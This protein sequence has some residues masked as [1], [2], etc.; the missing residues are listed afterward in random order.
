MSNTTKLK[1]FDDIRIP[2]GFLDSINFDSEQQQYNYFYNHPS[3]IFST[4]NFSPIHEHSE[5]YLTGLRTTFEKANYMMYEFNNKWYYA[6][7]N[8]IVQSNYNS[9]TKEGTI[10]IE[11]EID[12]VQTHLMLIKAMT[13]LFTVRRHLPNQLDKISERIYDE[14]T[15]VYKQVNDII[16]YGQLV[17]NKT[18]VIKWIVFVT[19]RKDVTPMNNGE[20]NPFSMFVFPIRIGK[21]GVEP[22]I[23]PYNVNGVA[24]DSLAGVETT[25]QILTG[26]TTTGNTMTNNCVNL[27][28]IDDI[29]IKWN[30]QNDIIII[31]DTNADYVT[32]PVSCIKLLG[33][34]EGADEEVLPMID[35]KTKLWENLKAKSAT[36]YQLVN[37]TLCGA[38]IANSYG[39]MTLETKNLIPMKE[40]K[41]LKRSYVTEQGSQVTTLKGYCGNDQTA[42]QMGI[43]STG[44]AQTILS[45]STATYMQANKNAF[46]YKQQSLNVQ[47]EQLNASQALQTSNLN[48]NISFG[49][50]QFNINY[51]TIGNIQFAGHEAMGFFNTASNALTS[52][53]QGF[54]T[55]GVLGG[56]LN[57]GIGLA[58]TALKGVDIY[59][60]V[61]NRGLQEDRDSYS[62][63]YAQQSVNL[64]QQQAQQ[65]MDMARKAFASENADR[66]LQPLTINQ[67]G[68][69]SIAD[70][71]NDL[72]TDCLITW[73]SDD[74]SIKMANNE[75]RR[76]GSF[77]ADY[78]NMDEMLSCRKN[79]NRI[80]VTQRLIL[81]LNQ[82]QKEIIEGAFN[83][84]IRFWN[85][86]TWGSQEKFDEHFMY[87]Y[88]CDS[89]L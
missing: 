36:E 53:A 84:G 63:Q 74:Y 51:G 2:R 23:A 3:E 85:Y 17:S 50:R 69:S 47:Q 89:H 33:A 67:M 7:V 28:L 40:F 11:F 24:G 82:A 42:V 43:K 6:H 56:V 62:M 52:T 60:D 35:I 37:S 15:P 88:N 70:Y 66:A 44:K 49:Q 30:L 27:Y 32:E 68:T 46:A 75:L 55:G 59:Q 31:N 14:I 18:Q 58:N 20:L 19:K 72:W 34:S 48:K 83:K 76:D 86:S 73:C 9:D 65:N 80:Q 64:Q 22:T 79:F 41:L 1:L 8:G 21:K 45:N 38:S 57:G 81:S 16:Q 4:D 39:V 10:K 87:D 78:Y 71:Q 25:I 26:N 77:T 61:Q 29:P 5:V 13:N 12:L 54:A